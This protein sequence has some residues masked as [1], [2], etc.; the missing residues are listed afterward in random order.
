LTKGARNP[1]EGDV[2]FQMRIDKRKGARTSVG[3]EKY[4]HT[5]FF[6]KRHGEFL[7]AGELVDYKKTLSVF[8]LKQDLL[9]YRRQS[10][11]SKRY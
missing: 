10:Y 8:F 4:S 6:G 7:R 2:T 3:E 11:D 5:G 9:W 1:S